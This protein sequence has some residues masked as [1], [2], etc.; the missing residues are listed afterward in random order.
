MSLTADLGGPL[1]CVVGFVVVALSRNV[2]EFAVLSNDPWLMGKDQVEI[3]EDGLI[4][5]HD[6]MKKF[7]HSGGLS[8]GQERKEVGESLLLLAPTLSRHGQGR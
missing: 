1:A 5:G 2:V 4:R 6:S 8:G 7:R 3:A